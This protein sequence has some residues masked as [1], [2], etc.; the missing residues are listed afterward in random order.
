MRHLYFVIQKG[1][2]E[3]LAQKQ[4]NKNLNIVNTEK[5]NQLKSTMTYFEKHE[6]PKNKIVQGLELTYER[7]LE[8]KKQKNSPLVVLR[9][10]KI[11]KIKP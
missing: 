11:V 1:K 7:L 9:E 4:T 2:H 10:N 3:F 8:F 6:E 5:L